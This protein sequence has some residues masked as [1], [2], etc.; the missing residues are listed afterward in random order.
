MGIKCIFFDLDDTLISSGDAIIEHHR[1]IAARL[2]LR[3]PDYEEIA[4]VIGMPWDQGL[5]MIWP[6]GDMDNFKNIYQ[7]VPK[8]FP[9]SIIAGVKP[10]LKKLSYN[11]TL[12]I[13]TGRDRVSTK[14]LLCEFNIANFFTVVSTGSDIITKPDPTVFDFVLEQV[15][16]KFNRSDILFTGDAL[17]DAKCAQEASVEFVGVETGFFKRCDFEKYGVKKVITNIVEL[18]KMLEQI[19]ILLINFV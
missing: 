3:V 2:N 8:K 9:I 4:K 14:R 12:G 6:N 18:P 13:I 7:S 19:K 16:H 10:L 1:N 15:N 11:Y 5:G 17:I